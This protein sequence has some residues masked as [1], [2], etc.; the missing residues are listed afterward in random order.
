[1]RNWDLGISSPSPYLF[2]ATF[3]RPQLISGFH[4]SS[5][6]LRRGNTPKTY[7]LLEGCDQY[8]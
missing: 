5:I 6:Q 7:A 1:M 2:R 3:Q 8:A 4:E